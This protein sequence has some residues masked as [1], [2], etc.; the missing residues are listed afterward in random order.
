[1]LW[2]AD[3]GLSISARLPLNAVRT[4]WSGNFVGKSRES[5]V[6]QQRVE[7]AGLPRI[8]KE[9]SAVFPLSFLDLA[10]SS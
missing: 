9:A 6:V 8:P 3:Y 2:P 7:T 4:G 10:L 5:E 1:M